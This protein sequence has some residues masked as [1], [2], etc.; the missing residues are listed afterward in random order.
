MIELPLH[1]V[2]WFTSQNLRS[3]FKY[4]VP[5]HNHNEGCDFPFPGEDKSLSY[6][7]LCFNFTPWFVRFSL[8]LV[9]SWNSVTR[10]F[11]PWSAVILRHL[12]GH[13]TSDLL[14][15]SF[16]LFIISWCIWSEWLFVGLVALSIYG[17]GWSSWELSQESFDGQFTVRAP[18]TDCLTQCGHTQVATKERATIHNIIT[19]GK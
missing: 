14:K 2:D 9:S 13:H 17:W 11:L 19:R 5:N 18:V 1:A 15:Q 8:S 10:F 3:L 6:A 12:I 4:W 16:T 7:S